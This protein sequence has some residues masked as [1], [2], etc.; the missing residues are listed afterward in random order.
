[1]QVVHVA[2]SLIQ[3]QLVLGFLRAH[4]IEAWLENEALW[5]VRGEVGFDRA[6]AP[7]VL[8]RD[9]DHERA[10]ALVAEGVRG[11]SDADAGDAPGAEDDAGT[12]GTEE[13]SA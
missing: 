2:E 7:K 12:E 8:V 1:V 4:G 9:G 13:P 11:A 5:G 3:A 10:A 6:S